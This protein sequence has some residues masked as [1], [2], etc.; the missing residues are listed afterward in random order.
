M[1]GLVD[2]THVVQSSADPKN[3]LAE[4]QDEMVAVSLETK[5][6]SRV[7]HCRPSKE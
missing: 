5:W 3:L 1:N 7:F 6:G 4:S 2:G